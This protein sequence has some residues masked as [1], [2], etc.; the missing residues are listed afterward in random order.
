MGLFYTFESP[1][2]AQGVLVQHT[3]EL[4]EKKKKNTCIRIISSCEKFC[5]KF[6]HQR[7]REVTC[8]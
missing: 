5:I 2:V 3:L 6:I 1:V 4:S 8:I 7:L